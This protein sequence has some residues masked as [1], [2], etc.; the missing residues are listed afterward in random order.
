[1]SAAANFS[2][3]H[4]PDVTVTV[5]AATGKGFVGQLKNRVWYLKVHT[6]VEPF[7]VVLKNASNAEGTELPKYNSVPT[8]DYRE[9]GWFYNRLGMGKAPSG[10]NAVK[11]YV[12]ISKYH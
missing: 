6:Q 8:V 2:T 1:M 4:K 7:A 5:K 12:Y 11:A 10:K 3:L 9:T